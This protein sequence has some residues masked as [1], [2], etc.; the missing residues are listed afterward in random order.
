MVIKLWVEK[1]FQKLM[2]FPAA[3]QFRSSAAAT[4][5][6]GFQ[7]LGGP[8]WGCSLGPRALT[9]ARKANAGSRDRRTGSIKCSYC[10]L[11][12]IT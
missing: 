12:H 5:R 1:T 6:A 4:S 10:V 2:P 7:E 11:G 3:A 9:A 8:A